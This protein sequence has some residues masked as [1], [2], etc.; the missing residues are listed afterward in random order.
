MDLLKELNEVTH[1]WINNFNYG[2]QIIQ[3]DKRR[4]EIVITD[5]WQFDWHIPI[6]YDTDHHEFLIDLGGDFPDFPLDREH[7]WIWLGAAAQRELWA[8]R[9]YQSEVS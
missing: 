9:K 6:I 8:V 5:H 4:F 3:T 1:C 7:V 2:A